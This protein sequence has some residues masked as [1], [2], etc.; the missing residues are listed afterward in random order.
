MIPE[1]IVIKNN[2][3]P[4]SPGI[5]FYYDQ[6]GKLLYIGKATSLKKR[7]SSYFTKAHDARI[8]DLVR[9]IAKIE[10]IETP[11]VIEALVL[12]ANQIRAYQPPYNILE[13]DDKS[14]LYFCLTN[15]Q[16]P[17]PLLLRG[18]DLERL[19]IQPF[20]R[21]LSD[22][23]KR[24]F[25]AVYGPYTNGR[26]IKL[27]LDLLRPVMPWSVCTPPGGSNFPIE[28][29]TG[30]RSFG[31]KKG[32]KDGKP[33]FDAQVKKCP[34]VCRG[35]MTVREYRR[36]IA[37]LMRF[38][39]GKKTSVLSELER[40]MKRAAKNHQFEEA[41]AYRNR[42]QALE[43]INDVALI[44]RDDDVPSLPFSKVEG[45]SGADLLGRIEA[46]DIAHISGSAAVASM[47]VFEGG[48]P[49]KEN[50]RR[51]RIK[52]AQGGDDVASMEEV[53]RRRLARAQHQP[54]AWPLPD[55]FVIDGGEGQVN[56]VQDV[57]ESLGVKVPV[58][59]IAKGFDRKQ[60]R[61]VSVVSQPEVLRAANAYKE[62]LQRAR[63]EAH[64]FA[65]AYHRNLRARLSGLKK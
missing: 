62:V 47:V 14:F 28:L 1:D 17:R 34:G 30:Q 54:I 5:Y 56:R 61:L 51:F 45:V 55:L 50:Y 48:R 31:F 58:I 37:R 7:V 41:A 63:D 35:E 53:M 29:F 12:E 27:A 42:V 25:L 64:R 9:N 43:H 33:C 26:A 19:G 16:Y 8:E 39:E 2:E 40:N 52:V 20:S 46:Y 3:L 24:Y 60:D 32:N 22:K 13:K 65:G 10:Y 6:E 4:E 21:K 11:T 18:R 57:V 38:F 49:A 23:A 59:G 44:L 15:E 36:G